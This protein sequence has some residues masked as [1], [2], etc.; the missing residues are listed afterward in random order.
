M[1][2]P[3]KKSAKGKSDTRERIFSVAFELIS[4]RGVDKVSVR[5]I[6]QKAGVTKPVLYYYFKDKDDLCRQLLDAELHRFK[7]MV[8]RVDKERLHV[9]K[10]LVAM[11]E[12]LVDHFKKKPQMAKILLR[13]LCSSDTKD[14]M[15][16]LMMEFKRQ[17]IKMLGDALSVAEK[18]K[19]IL[20]GRA[21]EVLYM[22]SAIFSFFLVNSFSNEIDIMEPNL[23]QRFAKVIMRGVGIK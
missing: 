2:I 13:S 21:K 1:R 9:E 6:V 7:E 22:T 23:P 19:E 10:L 16:N 14:K 18:R 5:E 11:F 17:R 12:E 20:P 15:R 8:G 4:E 3:V